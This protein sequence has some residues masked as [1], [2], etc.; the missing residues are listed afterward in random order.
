MKKKILVV[1]NDQLILEFMN[2]M[3][4]KE[5]HQVVTAEGGLSALDIL[6]TYTPD[7]IFVDLVMPNFDGKKLCKVIGGMQKL[8]DAYL[9]ILSAIA[10]DEGINIAELGA[11]A[12]I[13][14]GP[15]NEMAQNI[16]TVLDQSDLA[17]SQYLSGEVIGVESVYPRRITEELLSVKRHFEIILE[18]MS[19]GFLE[20]TAKGRIVYANNTALALIKIPEE[21]LLGSYFVELFDEDGRQ[22]IA[23]LIKT[24]GDKLKRITE[25]SPVSLNEYLV[26]LDIIPIDGDGSTAIIILNDVSEKKKLEAQLQYAQRIESIGTLAGGIAH[27]FNNLLMGIQ[28]NASLMLLETDSDHPNYERL[29]NIEKMVQSGSKL[30]SQLLGYARGG[31][32]EVKPISLNQIVKDTSDTFGT[33]RK[34]IRVHQDLDK[35]LFGILA[36]QGQIEQ[37][38]LNLYVNA[39]DAMPQGGDL[40]LKTT[41]VTH[42]DMKNKP[43]T[44]RPGNYALLTV[45]DTGVGMDKKT[46]ERIF[47]PFFTTKGLARGTGLGLASV[48]GIVKAHGGYIDV[49]S[50]KGQGTTFHVY[51]PAIKAEDIAKRAESMEQEEMTRGKET[52]LLVDDEEIIIDVGQGILETLGY[53]VLIAEGGKE[54]VDIY[55]ANKDKIDMVILDM[56]MP[57]MGGGETYDRMKEVNPDIKVLLSSGYSINGQ[58]TE[59]LKRGCNGFIQ[60]PFSVM[61]LSQRIREVLES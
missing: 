31:R 51:L 60:K 9:I 22:Q 29:T 17:P 55:K 23:E 58:A 40:F 15:F 12:C 50:E 4:S 7:V 30:T 49:D 48:Y 11:N 35:D 52:V 54:A 46:L 13:A 19:E 25:D 56:I 37:V 6:K 43:Y 39:A 33:T 57:D 34:D 3:L 16:L 47:D 41:N 18:R 24:M 14:K 8:K 36:D 20:I 59:I 2:D 32:Y 38:L 26:T 28:G 5:G 44:P 61:E 45:R 1:D 53:K 42:E 21:K 27:N 10:A